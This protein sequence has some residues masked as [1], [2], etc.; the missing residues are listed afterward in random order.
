MGAS[1]LQVVAARQRT[2][3]LRDAVMLAPVGDWGQPRVQ[4]FFSRVQETRSPNPRAPRLL[5]GL[6]EPSVTHRNE[7]PLDSK[8]ATNGGSKLPKGRLSGKHD[9]D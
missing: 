1:S 4:P 9:L 7:L 8:T 2:R 6:R 3:H 5:P